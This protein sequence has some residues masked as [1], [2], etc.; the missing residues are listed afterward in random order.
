MGK[1]HDF[2]SKDTKHKNESKRM[3]VIIRQLIIVFLCL[4]L[5]HFAIDAFVVKS[6]YGMIFWAV[7]LA[8]DALTM[9]ISYSASKLIVLT[10]FI[11]QKTVWI[12]VAVLLFGWEG[13]FQFFL[14][15]L[16][17]VYSFGEAGY[18]RKKVLF[19]FCGFAI[20][21]IFLIFFKGH[22]ARI[23]ID[24]ADKSIQV[25]NSLAFVAMVSIVSFSFSKESQ[26]MED[27]LIS[28]NNQLRKQASVDALTGLYNRRS[29]MEFVN[30]LV[31]E[32]RVFSICISDI[33]FFKNINDTYGHDFGDTVLVEISKLL[34]NE[35]NQKGFVS[36]WGG[37][38]FLIILLDEN[39]DDAYIK[40]SNIRDKVKAVR[41]NHGKDEISVKMTYG[42]TEY[43][44]S[45][46]FDENVKEADEK[47]YLGKQNGRD[48]IVY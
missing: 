9:G 14:V 17:I 29:T 30:D 48:M 20:F 10:V 40:I 35:V 44:F 22:P 32:K 8:I 12:T 36:R 46:S 1:L 15:L 43:D 11:L 25:V 4:S 38:E 31:L 39:G 33:D 47:L 45:K 21:V 18:S 3:T 6:V 5:F 28:Y 26:Q 7:M 16:F 2:I 27:K 19:G 37:E 42:L 23:S 24:S 13:G 34:K 41:L